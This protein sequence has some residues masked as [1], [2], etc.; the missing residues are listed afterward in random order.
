MKIREVSVRPV[1]SIRPMS[2]MVSVRPIRPM[3]CFSGVSRR[4]RGDYGR[5]KA[6]YGESRRIKNKNPQRRVST[7]DCEIQIGLTAVRY[8]EYVSPPKNL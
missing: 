8:R 6:H 4:M 5:T 3:Q 1:K 7:G 2:P